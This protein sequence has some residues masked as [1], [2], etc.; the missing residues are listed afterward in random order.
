MPFLRLA[1]L[2]GLSTQLFLSARL[3]DGFE[4]SA[5]RS[6]RPGPRPRDNPSIT[7]LTPEAVEKA[8]DRTSVRPGDQGAAVLR[9]QI[10]LDRANYSPGEIDGRYGKNL[11]NAIVAFQQSH[12]LKPDGVVGPAMWTALNAGAAPAL[13][14]YTISPEDVAGPFEPV[15]PDL[16]AQAKLAALHYESALEGLAEKFHCSPQ[17]LLALNPG[18]PVDQPGTALVVPNVQSAAPPAAAKV[19]VD[20]SGSSVTAFDAAGAVLARFPASTGSSHDP[21]PVGTWK[22]LG[23]KKMPPFH[24][25]PNLFWDADGGD[26][27]ATIA[28]GPN[29]PVGVVW[30]ALSKPH[31]G[32]HGT[33]APGRIGYS[34]S[35]GCIRLTNWDALKLA[36]M[37]KPGTPAILQ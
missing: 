16:Q 14:P 5:Y 2:L 30:I 7:P 21:L 4:S 36:A 31:Y 33:P 20:A 9:L 34:E 8:D 6:K 32:I 11:R 19:V 17:T 37:V 27:Q 3:L 12:D 25:N 24:Y 28:A 22:I 29:N 26:K 13:V 1:L 23:V 18:R 10:L 15:P 35:H